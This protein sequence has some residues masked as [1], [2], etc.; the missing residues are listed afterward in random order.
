MRKKV[1]NVG[2][3]T[4]PYRGMRKTVT[5]KKAGNNMKKAGSTGKKRQMK[6]K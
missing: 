2:K 3:G 5:M 4:R 6:M 1:G